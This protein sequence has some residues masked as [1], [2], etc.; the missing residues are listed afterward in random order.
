MKTKIT[1]LTWMAVNNDPKAFKSLLEILGKEYDVN[2]VI[3]LYQ[4][5]HVEKLKEIKK[6]YPV[7]SIEVDVKN[8]TA[9]KEIYGIVKN[10]ILPLVREEQNLVACRM[11][12]LIRGWSS[13]KWDAIGIASN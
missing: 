9:H 7:T 2:K 1:I 12:H 5:E 6:I 10:K 4:K 13:P 8:P 11:A 3:Y